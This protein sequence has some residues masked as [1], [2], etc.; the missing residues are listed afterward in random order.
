MIWVLAFLYFFPMA[1]GIVCFSR[2]LWIYWD[3]S[4][5]KDGPVT[6]WTDS[7]YTREELLDCLPDAIRLAIF[8]VMNWF[9][10]LDLGWHACDWIRYH[11]AM[12]KIKG[13]HRNYPNVDD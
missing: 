2:L 7:E 9:Y 6:M 12:A 5:P 11:A 3:H 8:P 10:V 13:Y 4:I 1:V